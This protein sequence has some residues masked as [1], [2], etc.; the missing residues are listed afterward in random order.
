MRVPMKD[1][2]VVVK[3]LNDKIYDK[4]N[5]KKNSFGELRKVIRNRKFIENN[6][7]IKKLKESVLG[8]VDKGVIEDVGNWEIVN[9]DEMDWNLGKGKKVKIFLK[10]KDMGEKVVRKGID[11]KDY[12][13]IV[14]GGVSKKNELGYV[15]KGC[16]GDEVENF[17]GE[18]VSGKKRYRVLDFE[19]MRNINLVRRVVV[20]C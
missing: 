18:R 6:E 5:S 19:R 17:V 12:W 13:L 1:L 4:L 2:D 14:C 7:F 11:L 10:H 8:V 3:E 9:D 16:S 20:G 15:L